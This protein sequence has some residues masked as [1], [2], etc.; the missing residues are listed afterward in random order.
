MALSSPYGVWVRLPFSSGT[1][2][3][4]PI[5]ICNAVFGDE[6]PFADVVRIGLWHQNLAGELMPLIQKNA[7]SRDGEGEESRYFLEPMVCR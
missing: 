2:T 3:P 5:E 6:I 1:L 7:K 4:R